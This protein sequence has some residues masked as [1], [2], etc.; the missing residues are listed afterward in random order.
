MPTVLEAVID[1]PRE[2]FRCR[3]TAVGQGRL[4]LAM[5][6]PLHDKVPRGEH[7]W[8]V[9]SIYYRQLHCFINKHTYTVVDERLHRDWSNS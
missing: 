6:L 3:P 9:Q 2:L 1:F 5:K 4:A 8:A 7:N